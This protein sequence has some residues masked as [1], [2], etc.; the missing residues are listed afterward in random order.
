M[1]TLTITT[2]DHEPITPDH[3]HAIAEQLELSQTQGTTPYWQLTHTPDPTPTTPL[4]PDPTQP[5]LF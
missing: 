1:H 4:Y 3:L 2:P 5:N